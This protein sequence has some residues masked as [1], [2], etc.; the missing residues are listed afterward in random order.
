MVKPDFQ[1]KGIRSRLMQAID[2]HFRMADRYKLFTGHRSTRNLYLYRKLGYRE[3]KRV[4]VND[5][6]I[7]VFLEKYRNHYNLGTEHMHAAS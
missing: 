3:F 4:P 6:I 7:V 5:L 1:N 2:E